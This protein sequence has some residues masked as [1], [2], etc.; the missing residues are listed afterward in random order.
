MTETILSYILSYLLAELESSNPPRLSKKW[1]VWDQEKTASLLYPVG[2]DGEWEDM[3]ATERTV[4]ASTSPKIAGKRSAESS[5]D[6]FSGVERITAG[7]PQGGRGAFYGR[8]LGRPP[9]ADRLLTH[10]L[11]LDLLALAGVRSPAS[12][13][14][15]HG[16]RLGRSVVERLE[17]CSS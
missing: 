1:A 7:A 16:H 3:A 15:T 11:R 10:G 13:E 2:R 5:P 14:S 8:R 9:V 4:S 12:V 6:L 17:K